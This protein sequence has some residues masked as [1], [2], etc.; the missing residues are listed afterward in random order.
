MRAFFRTFEKKTLGSAKEMD[1][2]V[3]PF[4]GGR[5]TV[6]QR[7]RFYAASEVM[8]TFGESTLRG[9]VTPNAAA[10]LARRCMA[11]PPG[12]LPVAPRAVVV[13]T[14]RDPPGVQERPCPPSPTTH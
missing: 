1:A 11:V 12:F 3:K 14:Y 13:P 10:S 2:F 9:V 6:A 8:A 4:F 7:F 5:S